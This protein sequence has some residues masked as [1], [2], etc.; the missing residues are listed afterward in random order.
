MLL[1]ISC[2]D[3][4]IRIQAL[5]LLLAG[6]SLDAQIPAVVNLHGLLYQ[7]HVFISLSAQSL[8]AKYD[9]QVKVHVHYDSLHEACREWLTSLR[10]KLA[11]AS[12]L[13]GDKHSVQNL[14]SRLQV[15][16][17]RCFVAGQLSQVF[18]LRPF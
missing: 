7:H 10:E 15:S 11:S 8:I 16:C 12:D 2:V 9:D 5:Y 3:P 1:N 14:L 13:T 4:N 17:R 18:C 6:D